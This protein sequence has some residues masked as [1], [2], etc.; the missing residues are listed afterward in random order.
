MHVQVKIFL[1]LLQ[2][3]IGGAKRR[4]GI[5]GRLVLAA[6]HTNLP[7]QF[8]RGIVLPHHHVNGILHGLEERR[9]ERTVSVGRALHGIN[10]GKEDMLLLLHVHEHF[11]G[12][13]RKQA[14]DS[15]DFRV[16]RGMSLAYLRQESANA[17]DGVANVLV[18]M[19]LNVPRQVRERC[20]RPLRFLGSG[21]FTLLLQAIQ[22]LLGGHVRVHAGL[23]KRLSASTAIINAGIFQNA[24]RSRIRQR[25]LADSRFSAEVHLCLPK[26]RYW[27][28]PFGQTVTKVTGRA[29]GGLFGGTL[30]APQSGGVPYDNLAALYFE[31][32]LSLQAAEI[33]RD[34]FAYG[35]QF[36]G[37]ILMTFCQFQMDAA[38]GRRA[39]FLSQAQN[40]GD[41]SLAHR[42]KGKLL[43]DADEAAQSRA[44][45]RDH[46]ERHV[47]MLATEILKVLPRDEQD[48]RVF[49]SRGRS[50]IVPSVKNRQL[51][52][53]TARS[54]HGQELFA[55]GSRELEDANFPGRDEIESFA[56]IAFREKLLSLVKALPHGAMRQRVELLFAQAGKKRGLFEN[57]FR[58][59]QDSRILVQQ[60]FG[61]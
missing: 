35:S 59:I 46:L 48:F 36:G 47:R 55:P 4:A 39:G 2:F 32:S 20:S 10:V 41:Q 61:L 57:R 40:Q 27:A 23:P 28:H 50:R 9:F 13:F 24:A 58:V 33:A 14:L 3:L 52:E 31:K 6:G 49:Q 19:V 51:R 21:R 25:D 16:I 11:P 29:K 5:G 53:R 37:Q 1:K 22:D 7:D 8:A 60:A 45:N 30:C 42:G 26:H 17:R 15:S 56:G 18:V 38:F 34:E 44:D 54:F 12:N 43:D